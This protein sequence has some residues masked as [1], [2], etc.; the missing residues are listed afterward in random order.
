MVVPP[1]QTSVTVPREH[2]TEA[3]RLL[4]WGAAGNRSLWAPILVNLETQSKR[5]E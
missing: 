2:F 4:V 3:D 1:R 5:K